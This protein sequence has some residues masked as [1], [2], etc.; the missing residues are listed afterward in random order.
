MLCM[1]LI[2]QPLSNMRLNLIRTLL[3]Y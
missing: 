1:L 2:R 3:N